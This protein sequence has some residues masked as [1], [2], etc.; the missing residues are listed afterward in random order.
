MISST[1]TPLKQFEKTFIF[2]H[3]WACVQP[4]DNHLAVFHCLPAFRS[5]L[6]LVSKLIYCT[7]VKRLMNCTGELSH[8]TPPVFPAELDL[9]P[10]RFL[11]EIEERQEQWV[12]AWLSVCV[13]ANVCQDTLVENIVRSTSAW[14]HRPECSSLT[15]EE[16]SESTMCVLGILKWPFMVVFRGS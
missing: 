8:K 16:S 5:L 9:N 15:R 2:F 4:S 6:V 14:G 11:T 7:S 13:G 1:K 10:V 3:M 12:H